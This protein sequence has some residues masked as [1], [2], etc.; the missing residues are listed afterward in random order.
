[1][2]NKQLQI[3]KEVLSAR[4]LIKQDLVEGYTPSVGDPTAAAYPPLS[5]LCPSPLITIRSEHA[6]I[7]QSME[8][9]ARVVG[10]IMDTHDQ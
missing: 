7:G 5:P 6:G 2:N 4:A 1:M 3:S 10:F 8:V 9:V